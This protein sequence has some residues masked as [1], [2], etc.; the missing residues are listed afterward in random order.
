MGR[1]PLDK[2]TRFDIALAGLSVRLSYSS[3]K[4]AS[5]QSVSLRVSFHRYS[6]LLLPSTTVIKFLLIALLL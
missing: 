1:T 2:A 4:M 6:M 5:T 3:Y